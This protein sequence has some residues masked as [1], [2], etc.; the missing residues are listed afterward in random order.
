LKVLVCPLDWGIGHATRCVPIIRTFLEMGDEVVIAVDGRPFE[1]L[2]KEFPQC[3]FIRLRGAHINYPKKGGFLIHMLLQIPVLIRSYYRERKDLKKLVRIEN[4]AIIISDNRYGL[5]NREYFCI[6]ITH[7]LKIIPPPFIRFLSGMINHLI[8][9]LINNFDECWIP[10][11]ELHNGLAGILSH[12]LKLPEKA[13]YI[14]TL[15]RFSSS[16]RETKNV[17]AGDYDI[18]VALSGPEPQRTMLEEIIFN[19]LINSGL[20][21]IIVRGLTEK[22]EEWNLTDKIRVFSHLETVRMKDFM[23]RSHIIIC[24]SGYSSLMDLVTLGKNAILI[25]TPGQTEQEYL[26]RYLMEKKIYFSMSQH[27]FDL[28]YAIEMTRNF[29]GLVMQND[30]KALSERIRLIKKEIENR[31]SN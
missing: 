21:G 17:L 10:D 15:S 26:A 28:L 24:R 2:K 31:Q 14:G 23:L 12:P 29:P 5:W 25:P 30:Y 4:P 13:H 7:Q 9:Q 22:T 16:T 3:R 27:H 18:M 20:S 6:L 11:F 8:H 1:F 19:Q